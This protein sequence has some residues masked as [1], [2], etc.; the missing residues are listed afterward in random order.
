MSQEEFVNSKLSGILNLKNSE[1][2]PIINKVKQRY[3]M[4]SPTVYAGLERECKISDFELDK[5]S[6]GKG[7]F[8][9]VWK[10]THKKT[11]KI[12]CIKIITKKSIVQ[13]KLVDQ[14]NREIEIM[15]L[16]NHPHCLRLKN[17]FEDDENFYLLMPLASKGQLYKYLKVKKKFDE[18]TT[19]QILRETISALQCLHSFKPPIIHRDIKPEN[20]LLNDQDRILLADYGWS[21]FKNEGDVRKTFCGTPEYIA[22]EMLNKK[23]HD[24]SVDIWSIGVLMFELLAGYSP[25]VARSNQEL[26]TNIRA[27]KIRWPKDMSPSAK[28]LITKILKLNPA[29]RLSLDEILNHQWFKSIKIIKPLLTNNMKTEDDILVY[30]MVSPVTNETIKK[31]NNLLKLSGEKAQNLEKT[32]KITAEI[33]DK[34]NFAKKNNIVNQINQQ[35]KIANNQTIIYE[36]S[37]TSINL[38]KEQIDNLNLQN[39]SLTKDNVNLN[40]KILSLETEIKN[41]KNEIQKLKENDTTSLQEQIK[42]LNSE[43]EKYKIKDKER[44]NVLFDL[45]EKNKKIIDL[46]TKI[47]LI[48]NDKT[49]LEKQ[50]ENLKKEINELNKKIDIKTVT[51][52]ELNKKSDRLSKEKEELFIEYQK[53]IE[54]LNNKVFENSNDSSLETAIKLISL[55]NENM[56]EF[57]EIFKKKIDNFNDNFNL[58]KKEY[59]LKGDKIN[60]LLNDKSKIVLD[61]INKFNSNLSNDVTKVFEKVNQPSDAINGKI[62]WFTQQNKEL[63]QYKIKHFE[64]ERKTIELQNKIDNLNQTVKL[65]EDEKI[66]KEKNYNLK[67]DLFDNLKINCQ[68]KDSQINDIKNYL[69][70]N[71]KKEQF[72]KFNEYFNEKYK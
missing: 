27:L 53:K 30:H 16:L 55:L 66:P 56:N 54:S 51:I 64:M 52:E 37:G 5:N 34:V 10:V 42:T 72:L 60:N 59:N 28:N 9:Q 62:E 41:L 39:A 43:I 68:N 33:Q 12:Y 11:Q 26:Y 44:V 71:L 21:N 57:K 70:Q 7:G 31:L 35:K 24:T 8:G 17:H 23:G 1:S 15:Y 50:I 19:A 22:P 2:K 58:F 46:N 38:T 40:S 45:D 47:Q 3:L 61:L 65:L 48:E 14:M 32:K 20:L 29:E 49:Q 18:R 25:F 63:S 6:I 67:C 69:K 13:Q 36:G 4:L